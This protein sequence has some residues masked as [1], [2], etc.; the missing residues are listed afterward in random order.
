M[1]IWHLWDG[2]ASR[3]GK[4]WLVARSD[5]PTRRARLCRDCYSKWLKELSPAMARNYGA[6]LAV[7]LEK[8]DE[9]TEDL[10]GV[11]AVR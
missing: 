10:P 1:I 5:V 3:C 6:A 4:A 11:H 8:E 9:R 2:N 7:R